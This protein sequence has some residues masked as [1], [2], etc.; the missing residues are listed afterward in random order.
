MNAKIIV[1]GAV[2]ALALLIPGRPDK[3]VEPFQATCTQDGD[4]ADVRPDTIATRRA[5]NTQCAE[6]AAFHRSGIDQ[7]SRAVT[8][9][10]GR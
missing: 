3:P 7:V 5:A 6:L 9:L 8:A 2:L 10:W 1:S 4:A